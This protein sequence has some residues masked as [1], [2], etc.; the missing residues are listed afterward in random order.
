MGTKAAPCLRTRNRPLFY[1][2]LFYK[3]H[4]FNLLP[5]SHNLSIPKFLR[6]SAGNRR[7]QGMD[8]LHHRH[9]LIHLN[10]MGNDYIRIHHIL[11][12]KMDTSA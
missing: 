9:R 3:E 11:C 12:R 1:T 6:P 5:Y 8:E 2:T 4:N 7:I 10:N